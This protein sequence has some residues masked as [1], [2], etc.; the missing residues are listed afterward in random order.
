[1]RGAEALLGLDGFRILAVSE[2]LELGISSNDRA[3]ELSEKACICGPGGR[4][5]VF[6]ELQADHSGFRF[7]GR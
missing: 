5:Q 7:V 1:M 4:G 6:P 3:G 2:D